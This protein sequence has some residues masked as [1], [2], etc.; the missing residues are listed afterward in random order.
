MSNV[1]LY[2]EYV[3]LFIC[4]LF[5]ST[6]FSVRYN[7]NDTWNDYQNKDIKSSMIFLGV[8]ISFELLISYLDMASQCQGGISGMTVLYVIIVWVLLLGG[9]QIFMLSNPGIK[10][11]FSDVIG[12]YYIYGKANRILSEL[13]NP[14]STKESDPDI[15]KYTSE[16]IGDKALYINTMVPANFE[17]M[18]KSLDNMSDPQINA[19]DK[20]KYKQEL[21]NCVVIRDRIGEC[22]WYVWTG[23]LCISIL[24]VHA[25]TINCPLSQ[26]QLQQNAQAYTATDTSPN[27]EVYV[28]D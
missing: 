4:V 2:Y 6:F 22:C 10:S 24:S 8:L 17:K 18:W 14:E 1:Y 20:L 12:Y 28:A 11:A 21:L 25:S 5:Y 23:I 16:V 13:L 26:A 19:E 9:I 3:V 7:I 15:K 27:T